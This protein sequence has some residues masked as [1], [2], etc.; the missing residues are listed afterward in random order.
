[1]R[2]HAETALTTR[3]ARTFLLLATVVLTGVNLRSFLTAAG[4]LAVDIQRSTGL[5]QQGMA[6]LTFLPVALM[7]AGAFASPWVARK[8]GSR[9]AILIALAMLGLGSLLRFEA[10]S[11]LALIG[12]A[13]LCGLGVAVVQAVFPAVIKAQMPLWLAPV[14]GLYS[15]AMMGGGALGAQFSPLLAHGLGDW[16]I[17][18]AVLG[19][20]C[21]L[22]L[23]LA[24]I[25]LPAS[26]TCPRTRSVPLAPLLR[27]PRA[28]LLMLC[29]GLV[30]GGYSSLVAWLAPFYQ[31]H[32]WSAT[33]SGSLVAV[34]T[35][36]QAAA[37]LLLPTLARRNLDRRTW[38]WLSLALQ[39]AA[40][41]GL[42]AWP[43]LSPRLWAAVGGAGLGGFFALF[44]VV[45]LDHDHR[46]AH[47]AA[48]SAVMQGG[49]FFLAALAPWL[50]AVL[51]DCTNGFTAG[52]LV[53]LGCIAVVAG[54]T[55]KLAPSGYAA[56]LSHS[57]PAVLNPA[58]STVTTPMQSG[59]T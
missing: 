29:F 36:S 24:W 2:P 7:G 13:A 59:Q 12:T 30:N 15:A 22:A 8:L 58:K 31:T 5:S 56:S 39:A 43:D 38:L 20:P 45:A 4:P 14:M 51:H 48:L 23:G 16:H 9:R 50:A 32:G 25:A 44:M 27:C 3:P 54:L 47:A 35:L 49:G 26:D 1:M 40:F 28:W 34:M 53:Q 57:H 10:H 6:W 42:A 33:G 17:A 18:L 55:A 46:P 19:L 52:W 41:T 11:G 21:L 37:A